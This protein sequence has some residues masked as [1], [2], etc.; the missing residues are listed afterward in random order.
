MKCPYC[1]HEEHR[2]LE[3]RKN[4]EVI[5]RRREC[6]KCQGRF[7]TIEHSLTVYPQIIKKDGRRESFSKEKIIKGLRAACQKRPIPQSTLNDIVEKVAQWTL[8]QSAQ[9]ISTQKIGHIIIKALR[10]ID[11]VAYVRFASVYK[12]FSDVHDFMTALDSQ[13]LKNNKP[14]NLQH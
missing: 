13:L 6:I 3:T 5:R 9:E 10:D 8:T 7:S 4:K 12:T 2:V 1:I 11:D 14:D